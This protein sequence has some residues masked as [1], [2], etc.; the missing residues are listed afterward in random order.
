MEMASMVL[1]SHKMTKQANWMNV[2]RCTRRASTCEKK[3]NKNSDFRFAIEINLSK[4]D[5]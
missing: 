3:R 5:R 1:T 2:K 4:L